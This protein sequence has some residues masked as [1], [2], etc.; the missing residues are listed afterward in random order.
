MS[1]KYV[2]VLHTISYVQIKTIQLKSQKAKYG[3]DR[4]RER[5]KER[6]GGA[7]ETESSRNTEARGETERERA[8]DRQRQRQTGRQTD[9][10]TDR[11]SNIITP[12]HRKTSV[13]GVV[14]FTFT[15]TSGKRLKEITFL[16]TINEYKIMY[17]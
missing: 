7:R 3:N 5:Q 10:R 9:R 14:F 17:T 11:S 1:T 2:N 6:E 13:G 15:V 16:S 4:E 12:V 8:T